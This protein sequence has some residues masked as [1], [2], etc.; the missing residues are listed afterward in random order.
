MITQHSLGIFI[1]VFLV[2]LMVVIVVYY[3]ISNPLDKHH[4]DYNKEKEYFK[5]PKHFFNVKKGDLFM[6]GIIERIEIYNNEMTIITTQ[7]KKNKWMK[8]R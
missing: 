4:E 6:G 3:S 1:I 2:L 8:G 7:I 5:Y